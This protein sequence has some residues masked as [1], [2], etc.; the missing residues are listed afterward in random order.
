M[1]SR[2][3]ALH[4]YSSSVLK[5]LGNGT[6]YFLPIEIS[7]FDVRDPNGYACVWRP[8]VLS[9]TEELLACSFSSAQV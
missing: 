3:E 1:L 2:T 6:M 9:L 8:L 5:R 7:F 4:A